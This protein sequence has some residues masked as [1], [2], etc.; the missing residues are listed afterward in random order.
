MLISGSSVSQDRA[1]VSQSVRAQGDPGGEARPQVAKE[2]AATQ[3]VGAS[4]GAA[5]ASAPTASQ[6]LRCAVAPR[7]SAAVLGRAF[8]T[9]PVRV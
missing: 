5:C 6:M 1:T 3:G 7:V 9:A 4:G 2:E 8:S